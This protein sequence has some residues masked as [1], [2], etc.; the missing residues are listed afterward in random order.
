[1][2]YKYS[3]TFPLF[4][5]ALFN[6]QAASAAKFASAD[7]VTIAKEFVLNSDAGIFET[8][9]AF[10]SY[11]VNNLCSYYLKKDEPKKQFSLKL[12][13]TATPAIFDETLVYFE[14]N[15][16]TGYDAAYDFL[17]QF[18]KDELKPDI[19]TMSATEKFAINAVPGDFIKELSIPLG[20]NVK[21]DGNYRIDATDTAN[22][23]SGMDIYLLDMMYNK[24]QNLIEEPI[25]NFS[26]KVADFENRFFLRFV[27]RNVELSVD[28]FAENMLFQLSS[29]DNII[30]LVYS[31]ALNKQGKLEIMNLLGQ[32]IIKAP[33]IFNG[34][35]NFKLDKGFYIVRL[36][37]GSRVYV[38]KIYVE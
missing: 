37:A 33:V 38:R 14:A 21:V 31:E 26:F 27:K 18:G 19:F 5:F 30:K 6:V 12:F 25:Y 35:H 8:K 29:H 24:T 9:A 17:K 10:N 16:T 11:F 36:V 34:E 7:K 23:F 1:M 2:I 3:F 4:L 15:S 22:I 32:T 28:R 13:N 20:V